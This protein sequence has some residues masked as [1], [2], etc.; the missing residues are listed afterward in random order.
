[1]TCEGPSG[2]R[3]GREA[4][5]LYLH[6]PFCRSK[7]PFCDFCSFPHPAAE[8]VEAYTEELIRRIRE[9]GAA[10]TAGTGEKQTLDTVYIGGGTPTLLTPSQAER[11][12]EAVH[13][14][15]SVLP[16]A[17]VTVEGNPAALTADG[18]AAFGNGGVN[19]LSLGVQSAQESELR[20]LGR[21][22][23]FSDAVR[24][25]ETA[26]AVGINNIS[27]DFMTGIP[28]Q[29]PDSLR[30]T[31][32]AALA[33]EPDHLSAYSLSLEPGTP[34]G[35]RGRA[36]LGLPVDE[37]EAAERESAL[38]ELSEKLLT[39]AG[40][41]HY[42]I[43]NY[44]RP[45]RRSRHNLHT[46]QDRPYIGLG[47]GAYSYLHGA[48]YGQ[49]RDIAA[50][51]R[52]E[53]ITVD[54]CVPDRREQMEEYIMLGLRLSDGISEEDFRARFGVDFWAM[55]GDVCEPLIRVGYARRQNG[56]FALTEAGWLVSNAILADLV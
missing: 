24:A 16:D 4:V 1:M 35:R 46:W 9:A 53:D 49:S 56:R 40:Y 37:E 44:A 28:G 13:A 55:R 17:E 12:M 38:C 33:L 50:F 7:C 2:G 26:R 30:E 20:A 15:F 19:R 22:H 14:A 43:S 52:G 11:V 36:A 5:G 23:S 29:T 34:F 45:G 48:R 10:E 18:L 41:E 6:I 25:A 54:R 21:L 42:E 32:R 8:T 47:V 27:M 39:S 3:G 51:L 31:L